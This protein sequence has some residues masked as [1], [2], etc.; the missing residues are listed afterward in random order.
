MRIL[1]TALL[2]FVVAAT[3]AS[4][5]LSLSLRAP[6][7]TG[8][9]SYRDYPKGVTL[10]RATLNGSPVQLTADRIVVIENHIATRVASIEDGANGYQKISWFTTRVESTGATQIVATIG[11]FTQTATGSLDATGGY[12][13]M[14]IRD[15]T[16]RNIGEH[17]FGVVASGDTALAKLKVAAIAARKGSGGFESSVLIDSITT[18]SPNTQVIWKRS[19]NS[20]PP[21]TRIQSG[22]D[23]RID[24]IFRSTSNDYFQDVLTVHFEG[25]R[26]T[27]IMLKANKR[28][29]PVRTVLKV[30][31]PNGGEAITPC[32]K[33]PIR[34]TG[35][36]AGYPTT[37]EWSPDGGQTWQRIGTSEDTTV[38]WTVPATISDSVL[39]RVS[40]DFQQSD[41][42]RIVGEQAVA[43][44]V[45]YSLDGRRFLIAYLNGTIQEWDAATLTK[46]ALYNVPGRDSVIG[47]TYIGNTGDIAAL[48]SGS[49]GRVF[50]YAQ[51]APDP[52]ATVDLPSTFKP[53]DI[54][55]DD[56]GTYVYVLPSLGPSVLLYSPT[57][58]PG[59]T[60]DVDAP[61]S[62]AALRFGR[63][64]LMTLNGIAMAY[65]VPAN[66]RLY[67]TDLD[68][69]ALNLPYTREMTASITGR[70]LALGTKA[71]EPG[72]LLGSRQ[73]TFVYD[74]QDAFVARSVSV[75]GSDAIG[76]SFS[77]NEAYLAMGFE[78][79]PQ[80]AAFDV[81]RN[82]YLGVIGAF[83]DAQ[84]ADLEFSPDGKSV[85]SCALASSN[86]GALR[87]FIT[88]ESDVSDGFT[89]IVQPAITLDVV[90]LATRRIGVSS[91]TT[92]TANVCNRGEV[93]FVVEASLFMN[94]TWLTLLDSL[95][96]DTLQ[97]GQCASFR[98]RSIPNDTGVLV[99]TLELLSCGTS[100]LLPITMRSLDR[101]FALL[102]TGTDFGEICIGERETRRVIALRNDDP[103]DVR[104]NTI[105]IRGGL[106]SQFRMVTMVDDTVIPAG[107][108]LEVEIAFVPRRTGLDTGIVVIE[109]ADQSNVTKTF[110]IYGRGKGA[111]V[112]LSHTTLPFLPEF[113]TRTLTIVNPTETPTTITA[114]NISAGAPFTV[115]TALP[116]AIGARDSVTIDVQY[117]GGAVPSDATM[118]LNFDPC[119]NDAVVPLT[120]YDGE[121]VVRTIRV[122]ADPRGDA[123]IPIIA[124]ITERVAYAGE[125]AFEGVLSVHPRLFLARTVSVTNGTGEIL[126][127]DIVN[128]VRQIRL[129]ITKNFQSGTDTICVLRGPAGLAEIDSTDLLFDTTAVDFSTIVPTTYGGGL[130]KIINPDPSRHIVDTRITR[131]V[132]ERVFPQ[133]ATDAARVRLHAPAACITSISVVDAQGQEVIAPRERVLA[134]GVN[135]I[136]LDLAGMVAGTYAVI[137]STAEARIAHPMVVV[138]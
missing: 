119:A 72:L 19:L 8:T 23:Y 102:G 38:T 97:P 54:A 98:L 42:V 30:V 51:G 123:I 80:L 112:Q 27:S 58:Q 85:L 15:S 126:S 114:A 120:L 62:A 1:T 93:P 84:L 11:G 68:F 74:L 53:R 66:T 4:A 9:I 21:P 128:D 20:N 31:E 107:G 44:N 130:L 87:Q 26:R 29:Y 33:I 37:V 45:T 22:L 47:L 41:E 91:D 116:L 99:D 96:G 105:Y 24:V 135:E 35:A 132:I 127:Q 103:I 13:W 137:V 28:E 52:R 94:G 134:Q 71:P 90:T 133:P 86:N 36:I 5:Q 6:Y 76:F 82:I 69:M 117:Q 39:F 34:W 10:V 60:I 46:S 50:S 65:A 92:I 3:L 110:P 124:D 81:A 2:L 67:V 25:G 17:D 43:T 63:L 108:S 122:E 111:D 7:G 95:V 129:R 32:Q 106:V 57:L 118:T 56:A 88:P 131:P 89:R 109:Y 55:S 101:S 78:Y 40:Q 14:A 121:A 104:I 61:I 70:F 83:P 18:S 16:S 136:D 125:R 48:T 75:S 77:A 59:P 64:S 12:T 49:R 115:T 138:R 73:N 113:P 79:T 100:Y